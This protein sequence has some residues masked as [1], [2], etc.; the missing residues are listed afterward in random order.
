MTNDSNGRLNDN[1]NDNRQVQKWRSK[2]RI[3]IKMSVYKRK[4][5]TIRTE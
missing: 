3:K 1:N 2:A 4:C 5:S